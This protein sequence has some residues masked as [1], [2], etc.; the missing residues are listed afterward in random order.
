M[1][2][3]AKRLEFLADGRGPKMAA[4]ADPNFPIGFP[5]FPGMSN[6]PVTLLITFKYKASMCFRHL[7]SRA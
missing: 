4:H 1:V 5:P 3:A 6:R 2:S 7:L